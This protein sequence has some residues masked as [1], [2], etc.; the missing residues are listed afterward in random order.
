MRL[1][2]GPGML[3]KGSVAPGSPH[4]PW[5]PPPL[6]SKLERAGSLRRAADR[7]YLLHSCS[8]QF[9]A[10]SF[11]APEV[12]RAL[13]ISYCG[14]HMPLCTAG[15]R[16]GWSGNVG[17]WSRSASDQL[18]V[19]R[20]PKHLLLMSYTRI[21]HSAPCDSLLCLDVLSACTLY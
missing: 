21:G 19:L 6:D 17:C 15:S 20:T 1:N 12:P 16:K 7:Q 10:V 9:Y 11:C 3:L 5:S 4:F 18:P 14:S 8:A 13:F 2:L